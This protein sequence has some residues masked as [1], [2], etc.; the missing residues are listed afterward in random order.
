MTRTV[1]TGSST[2]A[3][4]RVHRA[5]TSLTYATSRH[6]PEFFLSIEAFVRQTRFDLSFFHAL[7]FFVSAFFA[8]DTLHAPY[9][10]ANIKT[11]TMLLVFCL[12]RKTGRDS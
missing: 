7:S 12:S 9:R 10:M 8:M 3:R 1:S 2:E 4:Q 5:E 11:I 6:D